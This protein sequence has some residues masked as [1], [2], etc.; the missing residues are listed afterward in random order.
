MMSQAAQEWTL[1]GEGGGSAVT[2]TS[3]FD[4]DVRNEGKALSYPIEEGGF[5][6]Y[7]KTE[8]PLS[9]YVTLGFQG[10]ESS[11]ESALSKLDEF[12]RDTVTLDVVTPAKVYEKMTLESYSYSRKQTQGAHM[13][14]VELTLIEVREVQTQVTTTVASPRNPTSAPKADTGQKQPGPSAM[15]SMHTN[16]TGGH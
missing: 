3:F 16:F 10:D 2:F 11:F 5:I 9:I 1:Y 8:S 14:V 15:Q 12:K 6:N 13:L 7:N 4:I